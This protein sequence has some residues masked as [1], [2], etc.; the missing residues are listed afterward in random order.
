MLNQIVNF[1]ESNLKEVKFILINGNKDPDF[2]KK[3]FKINEKI[4]MFYCNYNR[5]SLIITTTL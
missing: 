4:E 1:A 2:E 5:S 3:I